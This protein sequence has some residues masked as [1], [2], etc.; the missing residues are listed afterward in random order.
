MLENNI[1]YKLTL[2]DTT[3]VTYPIHTHFGT[4]EALNKLKSLGGTKGG[5]YTH[6]YKIDCELLIFELSL[7]VS[8]GHHFKS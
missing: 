4:T 5:N 7:T 6:K 1:H 2:L 3:H 8:K